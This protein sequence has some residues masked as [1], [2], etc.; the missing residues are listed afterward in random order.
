M[1][2]E[3]GGEIEYWSRLATITGFEDHPSERSASRVAV[4]DNGATAVTSREDLKV[5][6]KV[7]VGIISGGSL[8]LFLENLDPDDV[9]SM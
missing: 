1:G 9:V 6:D 5:G 4:L 7:K 3:E 2:K 8:T